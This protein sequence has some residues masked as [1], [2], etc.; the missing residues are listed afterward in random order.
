L[1]GFPTRYLPDRGQQVEPTL[2]SSR[3]GTVFQRWTEPLIPVTAPQDRDGNRS[4]YMAWGLVRLP[5]ADKELSVYATEAYYTGPDSRLRR[6]TYRIDG[7]VSLHA[8]A[9]G[10]E[11]L[12]KPLQ[13]S[14]QNLTLNFRTAP[15]GS[16]RVEMT[17]L[18]G[19]PLD[20]LQLDRCRPLQGDAI[21][22]PVT[23]DGGGDL[24][25]WAGQAVR[26]RLVLADADVYALRFAASSNLPA[27]ARP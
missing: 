2:M 26:L 21:E 22:Q 24:G 14:G 10:G 17:D 15:G 16:V 4:N 3:D 13:F 11:V 20:G 12:T 27:G 25:R 5:G 23:W 6:F 8:P 7:F 9:A 18:D 19:R 1:I